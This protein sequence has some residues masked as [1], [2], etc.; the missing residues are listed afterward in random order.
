M[1]IVDEA[2]E[3]MVVSANGI[4]TRI[5]ASDISRQGR[6]ATGVRIQNLVDGDYIVGVNKIVNPEEDDKIE[7]KP[8]ESDEDVTASQQSLIQ[9]S[10]IQEIVDRA[11]SED[12]E[13][14]E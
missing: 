14:E 4:V 7:I 3:I 9:N 8:A 1:T 5:K 10:E 13:T 11:T 6:P 12:E 2:D